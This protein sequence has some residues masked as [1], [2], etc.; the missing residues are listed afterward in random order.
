MQPLGYPPDAATVH[1]TLVV[2]SAGEVYLG[3]SAGVDNKQQ[4]YTGYAGG[5]LLKYTPGGD[6][7]TPIGIDQPC[8]VGSVWNRASATTSCACGKSRSAAG[9]STS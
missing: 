8:A 6:E 4:G 9:S 1:R 3:A 5:H 2:S 7:G